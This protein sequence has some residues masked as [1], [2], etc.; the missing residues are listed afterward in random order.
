MLFSALLYMCSTTHTGERQKS[1]CI[2]WFYTFKSIYTHNIV[3]FEAQFSIVKTYVVHANI[4]DIDPEIQ[5]FEI[6]QISQNVL[7]LRKF[8]FVRNINMS[9][10]LRVFD[11]FQNLFLQYFR[12]FLQ[13]RVVTCICWVCIIPVVQK[14]LNAFCGDILAIFGFLYNL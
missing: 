6:R 1:A 12:R 9:I 3:F 14:L 11:I 2:F 4:P 8:G 7:F 5:N 13:I 10:T